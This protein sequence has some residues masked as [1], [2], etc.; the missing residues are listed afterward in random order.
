[1]LADP[2]QTLVQSFDFDLSAVTP[3][4]MAMTSQERAE[5]ILARRARELGATV[6]FGTELESF[7]QDPDGVTAVLRDVA[8]GRRWTVRAD[9]LVA[10]DGWRTSIRPAAGIGVHGHGAVSHWINTVFRADLGS[11]LFAD[12]QFGLVYLQNPELHGGAG[13]F[14]STDDPGRYVLAFGYDPATESDEDFD[15]DRCIE[16]IRIGI[17]LPDLQLELED[18]APTEFAHR[19][20]DRYVAGRVVL[21][22]DAAHVMPPTGG[23]GGNTAVMDGYYLAWRLAMVINGQAGPQLLDSYDTERRAYGEFIAEWQ[24]RNLLH[25]MS[26]GGADGQQGDGAD[27]ADGADE[28]SSMLGYRVVDGAVCAEPDDDHAFTENVFVP[29]GRPGSRAPHAWLDRGGQRLSTRD[30]FGRS[31]VLITG[32]QQWQPA[33]ASAADELG[34]PIDV[35]AIGVA[36]LDAVGDQWASRYGIG[37]P[38]ASLVRPDGFV[39]WRSSGPASAEEL[40]KA[41]RTVLCR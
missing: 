41:M 26:P 34:V 33:A 14:G 28:L 31:F 21:A 2:I 37:D 35:Q 11:R 23:Q 4:G 8:G 7:H 40:I 22:G 29:T 13:V 39:A 32:T 9:H 6:R 3:A 36:G 27:G 18:V 1:V 24:Y 30:L 12:R 20:A 16:Q 5:P 17:G 25:R 15:A 19:L 10:A 38:G